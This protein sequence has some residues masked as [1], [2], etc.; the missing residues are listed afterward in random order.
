MAQITKKLVTDLNASINA[1]STASRELFAARFSD[2][3]PRFV[4]A[5][6]TV[7]PEKVA[8][9]R[10]F[11][12]ALLD[13][14]SGAAVDM[15]C[16]F[17]AN[18]YDAARTAAIGSPLGYGALV[19]PAALHEAN[20]AAVRGMIETVKK[21]GD[22]ALFARECADRVDYSVRRGCGESVVACGMHDAKEPRF[23]RVPTGTE[24][25]EFCI[26]LASRGAV[27]LSARR[28]GMV[29]HFHPKCDCKIVPSWGKDEWDSPVEGYDPSGIYDRWR[30]MEMER[31][32]ERASRNGTTVDEE[33]QRD[34]DRLADAAERGH[35][36]N[37][38]HGPE[39]RE[40]NIR[41][42][43]NARKKARGW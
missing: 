43:R 42:K 30:D 5:N 10:E 32:S 6:G 23:A 27:Y 20:D 18:F 38:T 21:T 26:M 14:V 41:Q 29:D 12:V 2:G 33:W 9:L 31:A 1:L 39:D 28:A 4:D 13:E 15:A 11:A 24:T 7:P 25:C 37:I 8:E 22:A 16:A 35:A 34:R 19:A 17:G 36:R 40:I 3:L